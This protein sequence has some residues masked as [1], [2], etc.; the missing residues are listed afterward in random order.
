[1]QLLGTVHVNEYKLYED[2][3]LGPYIILDN[4]KGVLEEDSN[5]WLFSASVVLADVSL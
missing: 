2:A 5:N 3:S 1:M 4:V